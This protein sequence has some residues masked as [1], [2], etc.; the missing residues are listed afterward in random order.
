VAEINSL[1]PDATHIEVENSN[2]H[3][4][5]NAT[6]APNGGALVVHL[7]NYDQNSVSDLKVQLVLGSAFQKLAGHKPV[8]LSPDTRSPVFRDVQWRGSTLEVTLASI[9]GYCIFVLQ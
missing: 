4:L 1:A 5:A 2:N 6:S 7:L 3:V 8:L 9:D